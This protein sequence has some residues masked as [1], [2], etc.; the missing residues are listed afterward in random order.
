MLQ[1]LFDYL[2]PEEPTWRPFVLGLVLS[3]VVN[4]AI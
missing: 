4:A 2:F 3:I 1:G